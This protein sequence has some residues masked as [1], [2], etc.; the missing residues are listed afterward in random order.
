MYRLLIKN[1]YP[2]NLLN[3]LNTKK[4]KLVLIDYLEIKYSRLLI[5]KPSI[6]NLFQ[7][8]KQFVRLFPLAIILV[9]NMYLINLKKLEIIE[10]SEMFPL[11]L[12]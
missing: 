12:K 2:W 1:K 3:E 6:D 5:V 11:K 4:F 9:A 10:I 7:C 8:S